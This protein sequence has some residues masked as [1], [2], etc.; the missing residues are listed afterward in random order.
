MKVA[1]L[2]ANGF[3][4]G[5][6]FELWQ[7]RGP[8]RPR[9]VVRAPAGLARVARFAAPDWR[10]ADARDEA[11]LTA[12]FKGCDAVVHCVVGDER[13]IGA[14]IE[15]VYRAAAAAGIRDLVYLSSAAV[16]GLNPPS[17]TNEDSPLRDDQPLAYNNAKVGAE[18]RLRA[19]ASDG[20]VRVTIL[21]PGVVVGPRSRWVTDAVEALLESRA[22]WIGGGAGICNSLHVDNLA[23]AIEQVLATP[24]AAGGAYLLGDAEMVT[25]REFY[26]GLAAAVGRDE[27]A[28]AEA[29]PADVN[30]ARSWRER[31]GALKASGPVQ[32]VLPWFSP[33]LKGAVNA[34]L[35]RWQTPPA[36]NPW[37]LPAPPAPP[38]A[39]LEMTLLFAC[40]T[41]LPHEKAARALAYRP[42]VSWPEGFRRTVLWL[43]AAGYPLA[44]PAVR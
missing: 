21:R 26:L 37:A 9:A 36:P 38:V 16:H 31:L 39:S 30:A 20:Q 25:W 44:R 24:S 22:W 10:I 40:A 41:K 11:A 17:G 2:G 12:G 28:F 15:P 43:E 8:H 13:V 35:A 19:L 42:P 3:I 4:G 7:R 33:R 32:A 5:R 34:A 6:L 29:A 1:I 27:R 23:H 14:T 18:R